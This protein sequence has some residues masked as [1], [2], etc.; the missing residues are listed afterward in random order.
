MA[1]YHVQNGKKVEQLA[2]APSGS[3]GAFRG[4]SESARLRGPT[5]PAGRW[6]RFES[7]AG[8]RRGADG[9]YDRRL[10]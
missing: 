6:F 5:L 4:A 9:V 10:G 2:Q 7:G 8:G 3:Q 1:A